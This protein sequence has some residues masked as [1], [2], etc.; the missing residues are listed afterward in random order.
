[1]NVSINI[2]IPD[3]MQ[4]LVYIF[5]GFVVAIVASALGR[6]KEPFGILILTL[7]AALGGWLTTSFITLSVQ[8]EVAFGHVRMIEAVTGALIFGFGWALFLSQRRILI[9]R[10]KKK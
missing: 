4:L 6:I 7:L 2:A 8:P 10:E 1:M 5:I 3:L 9:I